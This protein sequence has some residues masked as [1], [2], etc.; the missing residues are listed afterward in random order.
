MK[1][2]KFFK[3]I[4]TLDHEVNVTIHSGLRPAVT[5]MLDEPIMQ[6]L[7]DKVRNGNITRAMQLLIR[8]EQLSDNELSPEE[9]SANYVEG[10]NN[11][12]SYDSAV[13][14]YLL[15]VREVYPGFALEASKLL[16]S[17]GKFFYA[18]MLAK[19]I[20]Q[21][22][23]DNYHK[24]AG[25]KLKIY[26]SGKTPSQWQDRVKERH[27][28]YDYIHRKSIDYFNS[29]DDARE[30]FK[31]IG[32]CDVVFAYLENT[33][34]ADYNTALEMGFAHSLGKKIIMVSERTSYISMLHYCADVNFYALSYA[35]DALE[36]VIDGLYAAKNNTK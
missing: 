5:S 10:S 2:E 20:I 36:I 15:A 6:E 32:Y 1:I 24:Y 27:P 18:R 30:S 13:F 25:R 11:P 29:F 4:E 31:A 33:E 16:M 7:I 21:N 8:M 22:A 14:T 9:R 19:D 17:W 12:T 35:I 23:N 28:Q 3:K 34:Q 26:L